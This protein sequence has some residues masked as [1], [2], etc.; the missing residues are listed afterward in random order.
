MQQA[1]AAPGRAPGPEGLTAPGGR[2][3]VGAPVEP[4]DL[5]GSL[6][7]ALAA[8][9]LTS[10]TR[11]SVSVEDIGALARL[12]LAPPLDSALTAALDRIAEVAGR[13][14]GPDTLEALA[15]TDSVRAAA[16]RCGVHHSTLQARCERI[17]ARL[18]YHPV[19]T[20]GRLRLALDLAAH[21]LTTVRF[22]YDS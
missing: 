9:R 4:G 6:P 2:V 19:S 13:P 22:D 8:L 7:G 3:G 21:S 5:A 10:R 12:D 14:W 20:T 18:G 17:A 16:Q 1:S 15:T 11:P